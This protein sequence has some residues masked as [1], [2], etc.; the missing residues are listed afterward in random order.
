MQA[1]ATRI[2]RRGI[3]EKGPSVG[4]AL[5]A[6]EEGWELFH[7]LLIIL[8]WWELVSLIEDYCFYLLKHSKYPFCH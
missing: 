4:R 1:Y 2:V 6:M 7:R 5:I 3:T 8:L